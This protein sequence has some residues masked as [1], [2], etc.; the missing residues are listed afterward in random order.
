MAYCMQVEKEGSPVRL[1]VHSLI[2]LWKPGSGADKS[3]IGSESDKG[4]IGQR[5]IFPLSSEQ[6]GR[7]VCVLK[8]FFLLSYSF[9][10]SHTA[11]IEA[12]VGELST[13][14]SL[15]WIILQLG[16]LDAARLS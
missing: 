14:D 16:Y 9:L 1:C 12:V 13:C 2:V 3:L 11:L 8:L 10:L 15:W 7:R 6:S 5:V 4:S